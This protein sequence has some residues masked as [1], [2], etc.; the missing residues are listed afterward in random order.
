MTVSNVVL[1]FEAIRFFVSKIIIFT[2]KQY[3]Y[4][5][6]SLSNCSTF[7]LTF[8]NNYWNPG[9]TQFSWFW[10]YLFAQ[11]VPVFKNCE[12]VISFCKFYLF[13]NNILIIILV[14]NVRK[15][16]ISKGIFFKVISLINV[17]KSDEM[18][19]TF[20]NILTF[21]LSV[22]WYS[23]SCEKVLEHCWNWHR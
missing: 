13:W 20:W 15:G 23:C 9:G 17:R 12:K 16:Q 8:T 21:T 14:E 5:Q 2:N 10:V 22:N 4:L 7:L 11:T 3:L 19:N 6:L 18:K 1:V